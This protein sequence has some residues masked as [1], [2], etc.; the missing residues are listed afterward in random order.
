[1][2]GFVNP[3]PGLFPLSLHYWMVNYSA[4]LSRPENSGL[5]Y[6]KCSG[7]GETV[8]G[9]FSGESPCLGR[10]FLYHYSPQF[11]KNRTR[12][13]IRV[14]SDMDELFRMIMAVP[15]VPVSSSLRKLINKN[16]SSLVVVLSLCLG[17]FFLEPL[18]FSN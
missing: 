13:I 4:P 14:V 9:R 17:I 8:P 16:T 11:C 2:S 15:S 5:G 18:M 7:G 1:M 3:N 6:Y 10:V 12:G